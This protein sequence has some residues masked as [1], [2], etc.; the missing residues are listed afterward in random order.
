[1]QLVGRVFIP[2]TELVSARSV[3]FLTHFI[4]TSILLSWQSFAVRTGSAT[5][6]VVSLVVLRPLK[7][8]CFSPAMSSGG[9]HIGHPSLE[10]FPDLYG[11]GVDCAAHTIRPFPM[12][13]G[14]RTTTV[15]D[16]DQM[17]AASIT[18]HA[19]IAERPRFYAN[20]CS[21]WWDLLS[22][23]IPARACRMIN[24]ALAVYLSMV[25]KLCA[26]NVLAAA[27]YTP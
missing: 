8:L 19:F 18:A 2:K 26:L 7:A 13:R 17:T 25:A 23:C 3:V 15:W 20:A 16:P 24:D 1:M 27:A 21:S 9:V 14:K 12:D 6:A 10:L 22:N 11:P 5:T 4:P